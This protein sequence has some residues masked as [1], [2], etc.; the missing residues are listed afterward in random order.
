[1]KWDTKYINESWQLLS[2]VKGKN[3]I[4]L[5]LGKKKITLKT[6]SQ[7]DN[8]EPGKVSMLALLHLLQHFE[9]KWSLVLP[10]AWP[11]ILP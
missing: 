6:S 4:N 1:M 10:V 5:E 2:P 3:Y 8:F 11:L 9:K 7:H